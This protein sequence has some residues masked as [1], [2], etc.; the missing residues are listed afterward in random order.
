MV[1]FKVGSIS[2]H[3]SKH[4]YVSFPVNLLRSPAVFASTPFTVAKWVSFSVE[5][6]SR[7]TKNGTVSNKVRKLDVQ[8]NVM[9]LLAKNCF[10]ILLINC[11]TRVLQFCRNDAQDIE[12]ND[13]HY[14]EPGTTH[15]CFLNS[16]GR[17]WFPRHGLPLGF[18]LVGINL[19]N[20]L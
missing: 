16:W 7:N 11:F 15:A 14:L 18:C 10:F 2:F 4:L 13:K 1:T 9:F 8:G 12:E 19:N 17:W 5:L 3:Y 6:I 20:A